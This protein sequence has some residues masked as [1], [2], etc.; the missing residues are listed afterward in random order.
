MGPA[1]RADLI[2]DFTNVPVGNYV[3]R[4]RRARTSRSAAASPDVDFDAGGPATPPARSWS[5]ASSRASAATRPRRRSSCSC[6][7]SRRLPAAT[8]TR[9]LA[10]LEEMS[11]DLPDAPGRGDAGHGRRATR[12][13]DWVSAVEQHVDGPDHGEPGVGA[14]EVWEFYNATAD[15]HPMH[16]HEVLFEVVDRQGI[17]VDEATRTVQVDAES[18]PRRARSPGRP[19]SRTRSSP[20][21]AR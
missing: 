15:A 11:M 14:T 8:V 18:A 4:Q 3:L 1:E 5:S 9:P 19:A 16:I 2:V 13:G 10:L 7:R 12:H 6:R 17:V 20:T 21:P